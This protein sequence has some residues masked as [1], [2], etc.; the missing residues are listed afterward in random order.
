MNRR[1]WAL[2]IALAGLAIYAG[3]VLEQ[4]WA[5]K[6][7]RQQAAM[8]NQFPPVKAGL[9]RSEAPPAP[10]LPS[11]YVNIP[12]KFLLDRS[13]NPDLPPPP[14]PPPPPAPKPKVVPPLPGFHGEMNLDGP[15]AILSTGSGKPEAIHPGEMIGPF[16]LVDI[17]KTEISFEWDGELIKK[18]L[19]ELLVRQAEPAAANNGNPVSPPMAQAAPPQ[20]PKPLGPAPGPANQFGVKACQP[21]D[22]TPD[23]TVQDGFRKT[24]HPTPFGNACTWDPVGGLP[25]K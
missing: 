25:G 1:I 10:V 2:N 18:S 20:A 8:R 22:S 9:F 16:K 23:G 11:T 6:R 21:G 15:T 4:E 5:A 3:Y 17:T 19:D 12:N 13:R 7:A 14:P 24:S